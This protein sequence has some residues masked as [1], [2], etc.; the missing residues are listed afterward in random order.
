MLAELRPLTAHLDERGR[1]TE[2]FRASDDAHGFGQAYI[3]TASAG[4]VKAWHRH[5]VQVDRWY[6]VAGAAKVGIWDSEAMRG[7]TVIL[8]ADTPQLLII[9][10]GL[11]HGFTPCHGHREAAILNLPSREYDPANPD[12]E[13]RGPLAFPFRWAV[14]SR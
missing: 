6:C 1:L 5:K 8:A 7:Q 11:F 3:T 13:R 10:A 4:V 12:E 9:P 14:E 2:I